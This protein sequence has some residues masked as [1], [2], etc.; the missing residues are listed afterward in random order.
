MFGPFRMRCLRKQMLRH[1]IRSSFIVFIVAVLLC[2]PEIVAASAFDPSQPWLWV[3]IAFVVL[4]LAIGLYALFWRRRFPVIDLSN[5]TENNGDVFHIEN[6][7]NA[8]KSPVEKAI[9]LVEYVRLDLERNLVCSMIPFFWRYFSIRRQCAALRRVQTLL[10]SPTPLHIPDLMEEIQSGRVDVDQDTKKWLSYELA[11]KTSIR[12]TEATPDEQV[13]RASRSASISVMRN[14]NDASDVRSLSAI[15]NWSFNVFS[16]VEDNKEELPLAAVGF[17]LFLKFNLFKKLGL[18][19]DT[20]ENLMFALDDAY[21]KNPYHNSL[22]AAD[23]A[24]TTSYLIE[25]TNCLDLIRPLDHA[26]LILAAL[27]HDIDHPYVQSMYVF[28]E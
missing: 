1:S 17:C 11:K 16:L 19:M 2:E 21:R 9:R 3:F 6:T 5:A 23:V 26:T 7:L 22:H 24:Q 15:G 20:V 12:F 27:C 25:Q 13:G 14:S 8:L 18:D 10:S 28:I 4:A